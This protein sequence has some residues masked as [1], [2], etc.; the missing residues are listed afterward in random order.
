VLSRIFAKTRQ[1]PGH[2][3]I[4]CSG[5]IT[6]NRKVRVEKPTPVLILGAYLDYILIADKN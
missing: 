1:A 4:C 3:A 6:G 2:S 5:R